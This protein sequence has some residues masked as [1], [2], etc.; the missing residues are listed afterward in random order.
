M[1][2]K[3]PTSTH[4]GVC[5]KL[6]N[7]LSGSPTFRSFRR[8]SHHPQTPTTSPSL[9]APTPLP[10]PTSPEYNS[11]TLGIQ[12]KPHSREKNDQGTNLGYTHGAQNNPH[13]LAKNEGQTHKPEKSKIA[14]AE[15]PTK[16]HPSLP[17]PKPKTERVKFTATPESTRERVKSQVFKVN[18]KIEPETPS[19]VSVKEKAKTNP[20]V[21]LAPPPVADSG[22]GTPKVEPPPLQPAPELGPTKAEDAKKTRSSTINEKA[23]D[24]ITRARAKIR[25]TTMAGG[26]FSSSK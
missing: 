21:S 16:A 1:D 20:E 18:S 19:N 7:A 25:T 9:P 22:R 26:R 15:L 13:T 3:A 6:F 4:T 17:L 11:S 23:S 24:Y 14:E 5:E 8:I 2:Q 10:P 12:T